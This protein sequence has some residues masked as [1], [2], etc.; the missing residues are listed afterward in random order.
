MTPIEIENILNYHFNTL[1][2]NGDSIELKFEQIVKDY[3]RVHILQI[4]LEMKK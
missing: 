4:Y 2:K 1:F 3:I